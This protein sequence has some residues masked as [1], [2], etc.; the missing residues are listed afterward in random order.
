MP[1]RAVRTV[2]LV[3]VVPA[4]RTQP[5]PHG[6]RVREKQARRASHDCTGAGPPGKRVEVELARTYFGSADTPE[7][8]VIVT[9]PPSPQ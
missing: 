6:R 7:R 2:A 1:G 8:F 9:M 3:G 5:A 4:G